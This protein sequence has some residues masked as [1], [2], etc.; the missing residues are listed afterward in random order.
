VRSEDEAATARK[1]GEHII[2]ENI[3]VEYNLCDKRPRIQ[4]SEEH[5]YD[6][7]DSILAPALIRFGNPRFRKA[8]ANDTWK[9]P[10]KGRE[11]DLAGVEEAGIK[12]I[13]VNNINI[14]YD[15]RIPL[16]N[17]ANEISYYDLRENEKDGDRYAGIFIESI[18]EGV[19]FHDISVS[20]ITVNGKRATKDD[21]LIEVSD[22]D[23]FTFDGEEL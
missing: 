12:D 11:L 1:Q 7:L 19:R 16:K 23:N 17:A 3:N 14:Y 20:N 15:E 2:F 5:K 10:E 9:V 18:V 4:Q 8:Y 6:A 21:F 22:T 13:V